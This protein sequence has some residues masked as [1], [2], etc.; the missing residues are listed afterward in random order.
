MTIEEQWTV[1]KLV[2]NLEEIPL[3]NSRPNRITKIG[4]LASPHVRQ[5]LTAFLREIQDVFAWSHEDMPEI[6]PLV[7]VHRL[8]VSHHS[9]YPSEE[10]GVCLRTRLS[11]SKRSSQVTRGR[12]HQGSLLPRLVGK[13]GDGQESQREVENVCGLHKPKQS[14]P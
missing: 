3:K 9:S 8:N 12:L 6:D 2:E 11:Y 4:T 5:A 14:M 1:A 7:M 13:C 10:E